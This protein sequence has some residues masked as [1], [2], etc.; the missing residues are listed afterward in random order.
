[1]STSP[2]GFSSRDYII[3][4]PRKIMVAKLQIL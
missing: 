1:M 3:P 2:L 4:T